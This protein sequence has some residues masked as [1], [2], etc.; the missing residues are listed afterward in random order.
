[1]T[2]FA[3]YTD[4]IVSTENIDNNKN[5]LIFFD[6]AS[7][8]TLYSDEFIELKWDAIEKQPLFK[9]L[10]N[11]QKLIK[12]GILLNNTTTST[13][14]SSRTHTINEEIYFSSPSNSNN[15]NQYASADNSFQ[16]DPSIRNGW[17]RSKLWLASAMDETF[18]YYNITINSS[19]VRGYI[20]VKR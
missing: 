10:K 3:I 11:D 9:I 13:H 15:I 16:F 2:D 5:N 8:E 14:A 17:N 20:E 7:Y 19:G 18:P 6:L 1:M 4:I 12:Y